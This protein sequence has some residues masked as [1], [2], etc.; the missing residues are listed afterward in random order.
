M[1]RGI[2][3]TEAPDFQPIPR[4]LN[5]REEIQEVFGGSERVLAFTRQSPF[6]R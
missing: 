4:L 5:D 3:G 6:V 1:G 2:L